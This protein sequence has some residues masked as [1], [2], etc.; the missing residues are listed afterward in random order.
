MATDYAPVHAAVADMK[1][2]GL[3]PKEV[4]MHRKVSNIV[5]S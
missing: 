4:S 1:A 2:R 3:W 5:F